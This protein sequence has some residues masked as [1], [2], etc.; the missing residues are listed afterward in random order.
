MQE[1]KVLFLWC[2]DHD[3]SF[4]FQSRHLFDLSII[5]DGLGKFQQDHFTLFFI[6]DGPSFEEDI[7][8]YLSPI[9]EELYA[10]I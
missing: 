9:L 6:D 2:D 7:H 1:K 8:F 5:H 4:P 3:H 10:M